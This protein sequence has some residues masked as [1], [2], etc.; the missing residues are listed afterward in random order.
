VF[1]HNLHKINLITSSY[2]YTTY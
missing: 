1:L 2:S